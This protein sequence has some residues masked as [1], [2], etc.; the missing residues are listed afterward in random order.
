[1]G[2]R[3]INNHRR[4]QRGTNKTTKHKQY[5]SIIGE[6][7]RTPALRPDRPQNY[8]R[9]ENAP[10]FRIQMNRRSRRFQPQPQTTSYIRLANTKRMKTTTEQELLASYSELAADSQF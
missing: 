5:H 7:R 1:M 2:Q 4:K 6:V 9:N 3:K 8:N 10:N